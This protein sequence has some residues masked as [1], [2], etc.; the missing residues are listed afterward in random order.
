MTLST[1]LKFIAILAI[2]AWAGVSFA[3]IVLQQKAA[4]VASPYK[5]VFQVSHGCQGSATTALRV[6]VPAGFTGAQP[7][8][9]SGW[10]LTT[11]EDAITW[12]ASSTA[13]ALS[14][15]LDGEFVLRGRTPDT[16]GPLWFAVRQS[17]GSL[18]Q[19]WAERPSSGTST[20][21]LTYPAALVQVTGA[22][23][24]QPS[25]PALAPT[26]LAHQH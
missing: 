15:G 8:P 10:V 5:A 7:L 18:V 2:N 1:T 12:A 6:Q 14:S 4:P 13:A 22:A 16:P 9:K 21:G 11:E 20:Q 19:D 25:A 17:C 24:V 23:D 26:S 3:H